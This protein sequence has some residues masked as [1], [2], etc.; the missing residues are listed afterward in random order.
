MKAGLQDLRTIYCVQWIIGDVQ[1]QQATGFM[2]QEVN[3]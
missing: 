2:R 1:R 3:A